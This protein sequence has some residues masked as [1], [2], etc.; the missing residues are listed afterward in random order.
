MRVLVTGG[1]GFVGRAAAA[2]LAA[3]GHEVAVVS[4]APGPGRVGWDEAPLSRELAASDAVLNLAGENLFARRWSARQKRELV[5]SRVERTGYLARLA[6]N[7]RAAGRGPRAFVSASAV[8]YYGSFSGLPGDDPELGEDAPAG[9]GFLAA[10]CR[11]WE[12]A[13]EPARRGGM[14]VA[15]AR[16][17]VV[18]SPE[19]GALERMLLP[20]KLGL[21]GRWGSGRQVISWIHRADLAA[22]LAHLIEREDAAGAFNA[23]SPAPL[24]VGEFAGALGR[25]LGRPALLPVPAVALRAALGEV[26]G[27]LLGGQRALPRRTTASGFDFR[28]PA[29]GEALADLFAR[30]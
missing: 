18:L 6:A 4:R 25:A 20:F 26:A 13:C 23:A 8:G 16:I 15:V 12:G 9:N 27:V 2:A 3:R 7:A 1:T 29:V 21:G 10:L 5:A 24:P 30:R 28:F 22:L 19:G 14:R 17:G 11:D